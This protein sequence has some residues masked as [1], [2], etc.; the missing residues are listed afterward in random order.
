[1]S[2]SLPLHFAPQSSN[3][4]PHLCLLSPLPNISESS[5]VKTVRFSTHSWGLG[6]GGLNFCSPDTTSVS[7]SPAQTPNSHGGFDRCSFHS[8]AS[9]RELVRIPDV[10]QVSLHPIPLTTCLWTW[11]GVSRKSAQVG[12]EQDALD[13]DL[14]NL[15]LSNSLPLEKSCKESVPHPSPIFIVMFQGLM[16]PGS[17]RYMVGCTARQL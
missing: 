8:R 14:G 6:F 15:L 3:Y 4:S 16:F 5:T 11:F 7:G 2:S 9:S 13:F 1:M 17:F 10:N 12:T